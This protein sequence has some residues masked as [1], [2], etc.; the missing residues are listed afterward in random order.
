MNNCC[1]RVPPSFNKD[2]ILQ[3]Y[4]FKY[5]NPETTRVHGI[6]MYSRSSPAER[7][8]HHTHM[9]TPLVTKFVVSSPPIRIR[10]PQHSSSFER[11]EDVRAFLTHHMRSEAERQEERRRFSCT[12]LVMYL[13]EVQAAMEA[14]RY[15][16]SMTAAM[17]YEYRAGTSPMLLSDAREIS[18]RM[19]MNTLVLINAYCDI[20]TCHTHHEIA[21][22]KKND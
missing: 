16:S 5:L 21:W 14:E 10:T 8:H 18:A 6:G 9:T 13:C 7:Y 19:K 4:E 3:N 22:V 17:S 20:A 15:N 12:V 2:I 1:L 11:P